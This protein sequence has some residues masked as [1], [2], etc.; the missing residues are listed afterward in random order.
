M[1]PR[2]PLP[3]GRNFLHAPGP[4]NVPDRV[5][6][7]MQRPA[8][9]L[10]TPWFVRFTRS[11]IDDLRPVFNT[12]HEVFVYASNGHGAWEAALVNTLS[13]GDRV[14]VPESGHFAL[15]WARLAESLG[16]VTETVPGD[17]R[18]AVDP[19]LIERRLRADT[20]GDIK[21]VLAV[22]TD[23]ATGVT[24]DIEAVRR[25]IDAAGHPALLMVDA[26]ASLATADF[27]MDEWGVDVAVA[28]SQKALMAPPGLGI[29]A[30]GPRARAAG[31]R[32][33]LPRNY[34][35]WERRRG[36]E[37]YMWFSG[38]APEHLLFALREALD[39]LFEEGLPEAYA[40]QA[41]LA[42]AVQAAVQTWGTEGG[43][44]VNALLP[45][46]RA[47]AV[48]TVRMPDGF[49]A[50]ELIT[51]CRDRFDVT[52]GGG[53]GKLEG[54]C[55]R[56]AHMGWMN[57]PMVLGA[58]GCVEAGLRVLGVPHRAGGVTAALIRLAA[59]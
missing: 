32:A 44:E 28:A 41:R 47:S 25:A 57:T 56:I 22:H 20:A 46:E 18:R 19:A 48:T 50:R 38:T 37:Y 33:R 35:D 1:S 21:A 5:L 10:A 30:V 54:R 2:G 53:L 14:L 12:A 7:A 36:S 45:A 51:L 9:E 24:S 11:C 42:A 4:T 23:T 17:W 13:P 6:R 3:G 52:L 49:D 27:R 39:M 34:W 59:D 55:F 43:M 8:V 16:V 15:G 29:N 26:V 40:R 31:E 58:L